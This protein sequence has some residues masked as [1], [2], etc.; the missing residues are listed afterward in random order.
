VVFKKDALHRI[1][2]RLISDPK[3]GAV[4]GDLQPEPSPEATTE[5]ECEYRSIYGRMCEWESAHDSTF[6]FNGALMA[7]KK[8]AVIRIDDKQGADDANIAFA[9]IRNGY[10]AVYERTAIVYETV[11]E[12]FTVQYK[13]KIRRATGLLEAMR[14][15][16]DLLKNNRIFSRFYLIRMWMYFLSPATFFTGLALSIWVWIPVFILITFSSFCRAFVLNQFYLLVGF[17]NIGKNVQIWDS[18]SSLGQGP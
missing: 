17:M 15:N 6:N 16:D 9:A 12:S 14:A 10:R 13:Q 4:T 11:P 8:Q 2:T 1:I 5:M 3:I 18:T 7:F